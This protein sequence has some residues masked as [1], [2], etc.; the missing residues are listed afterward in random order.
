MQDGTCFNNYFAL[1][2]WPDPKILNENSVSWQTIVILANFKEICLYCATN[3]IFDVQYVAEYLEGCVISAHNR[4]S[5]NQI[6]G[7]M[8]SADECTSDN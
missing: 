3:F 2:C 1:R 4:H 8:D 6:V 7:K 5:K